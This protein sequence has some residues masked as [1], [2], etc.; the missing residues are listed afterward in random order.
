M[1]T[2]VAVKDERVLSKIEKRKGEWWF[3]LK[4]LYDRMGYYNSSCDWVRWRRRLLD[5]LQKDKD[6]VIRSR[7]ELECEDPKYSLVDKYGRHN[8]KIIFVSPEALKT[9]VTKVRSEHH[10][11]IKSLYYRSKLKEKAKSNNNVT[12]QPVTNNVQ[13]SKQVKDVFVEK[14]DVYEKALE[15]ALEIVKKAKELSQAGITVPD[16]IKEGLGLAVDRIKT[17]DKPLKNN[18]G[19]MRGRDTL[20]SLNLGVGLRIFYKQLRT[21]GLMCTTDDPLRKTEPTQWAIDQGLM[22]FDYSVVHKGDETLY[23]SVPLFTTKGRQYILKKWIDE[24]LISDGRQVRWVRQRLE[25]M[26]A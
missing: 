24:G 8:N 3:N 15:Y 13:P 16:N 23:Y 12:V 25:K 20:N 21:W 18:N 26:A 7:K 9:F 19:D 17:A 1:G 2:E 10:N 6:Y 22:K 5:G 11:Y 14:C 4:D